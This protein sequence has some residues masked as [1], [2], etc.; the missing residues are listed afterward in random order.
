MATPADLIHKYT[1]PVTGALDVG[2]A[3][4]QGAGTQIGSGLAGIWSAVRHLSMDKGA[5]AVEKFQADHAPDPLGP[6]GIKTIQSI[7]PAFYR[8]A[9]SGVAQDAQALADKYSGGV[10]SLAR[11][12]SR[13]SPELGAGISAAGAALPNAAFPEL[14]EEGAVVH[15]LEPATKDAVSGIKSAP[16]VPL[17]E[18]GATAGTLAREQAANAR[19]AEDGLST[20]EVPPS[21]FAGRQAEHEGAVA[22]RMNDKAPRQISAVPGYASHLTG[23]VPDDATV[24]SSHHPETGALQGAV[25]TV[26]RNGGHQITSID[27]SPDFQRQGI[28]KDLFNKAV[29]G[30]H[31]EGLDFH[32]DTSVTPEQIANVAHSGHTVEMNPNVL[33][34]TDVSGKPVLRSS[35]GQPVYKIPAPSAA[36]DADPG[37]AMPGSWVRSQAYADGGEAGVVAGG[38]SDLIHQYAPLKGMPSRA[39]IPGLGALEVKP[40]QTAR[41]AA[42]AY[43]K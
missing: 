36:E 39:T 40:N 12:G 18:D 30:A 42:A 41:A 34:D 2:R 7:A 25:V 13:I 38:L 20:T 16:L 29:Q 8:A 31:D 14:S 33:E 3:L 6:E 22:Q 9:H 21:E 23:T 10:D 5:D 35:N 15:A 24:Y 4:A 26:P 1:D 11:V 19:R 43:A 32:G 27:V 28:G 17:L 37:D